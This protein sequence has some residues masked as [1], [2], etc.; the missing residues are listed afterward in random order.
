VELQLPLTQSDLAALLGASRISVNRAL[1][2]WE[3]EALLQRY[4]RHATVVDAHGLRQ[5]LG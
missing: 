3:G 5:R 4:P 2:R 1:H